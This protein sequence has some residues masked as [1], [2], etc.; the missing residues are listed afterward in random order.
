MIFA[1]APL[2]SVIRWARVSGWTSIVIGAILFAGYVYLE[3][4]EH[5]DERRA[6]PVILLHAAV[7]FE[8]VPGLLLLLLAK[9]LD[10][11]KMWAYFGIA[12]VSAFQLCELIVVPVSC[13]PLRL[14][15]MRL[16]AACLIA[17]PEIRSNIKHGRRGRRQRG[18]E[19]IGVSSPTTMPSISPENSG[20]KRKT[21]P[22][23]A[24]EMRAEKETGARRYTGL[25]SSG[26]PGLTPGD[27]QPQSQYRQVA[28]QPLAKLR[29]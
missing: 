21:R 14:I 25:K 12:A 9:K 3:S 10:D 5:P 15:T 24:C 4:E 16:V 18:F 2:L 29:K 26:C 27:P 1:S 23:M 11:G 22:M 17:I 19:V 6:N 28:I 8:L 7:F 13:L 20:F